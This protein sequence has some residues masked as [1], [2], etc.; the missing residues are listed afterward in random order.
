METDA[1]GTRAI[2][3][4]MA[5]VKNVGEGAV[6]SIVAAREAADGG[7]PFTSLDDLCRRVDQ[8]RVNKRVFESLIKVN[9]LASL[10]PMTD[11]ARPAGLRARRRGPAPSRRGRRPVHDVRPVR[12][13][14][15]GRRGWM[16]ATAGPMARRGEISRRERLRWEKELLGLYLT[17]HP[18]GDIADQ[19]P[20]YVTAYTGDL[21][22]ESDQS[23]V[24]LGGIIQGTRRVITRAGS[25]ML[26]V[27]LEDLQGSV[28]VVV[29]PKVFADTAPAWVE[30][31]VVLVSGRVDHR[32]EEAKLLC[33]TVHAWEDAAA[34]GP[35]RLRGRAGP[36]VPQP[37]RTPT[38]ATSGQR[39]CQPAAETPAD[40]PLVRPRGPN[41]RRRASRRRRSP[42]PRN[43]RLRRR[44]RARS[45][46]S[47]RARPARCGSRSRPTC[48]PTRCSMPSSR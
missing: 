29:F 18:L 11:A 32:D 33:D 4:G 25:T 28:E 1:D 45:P 17:E 40:V 15:G 5:A 46:P 12:G 42:R 19:L 24:T 16:P 6:E 41:R 27:Q 37:R 3:F 8:Q 21:A 10:G 2:R 30:D 31:A 35:G 14:D 43:R 38:G 48:R 26:V 39:S 23:R 34:P 47:P 20:S 7:G 9:A 22:E 44:A 36:D 13:A